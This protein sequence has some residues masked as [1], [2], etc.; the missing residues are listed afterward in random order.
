MGK[1]LKLTST[2]VI[3]KVQRNVK[4]ARRKYYRNAVEK[5]KSTNSSRWWKEV[6]SLDGLK[7]NESWLHQLLSDVNPKFQE[8]TE[9]CNQFLIGLTSHF[10][11][12]LEYSSGQQLQVL[13]N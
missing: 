5:L 11:P 3:N 12:L 2:R 4:L 10:E 8:F 9:S 1:T 13:G 7:S 6:K